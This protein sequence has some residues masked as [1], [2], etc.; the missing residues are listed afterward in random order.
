MR[1][2]TFANWVTEII[3]SCGVNREELEAAIRADLNAHDSRLRDMIVPEAM[4]LIEN[5]ERYDRVVLSDGEYSVSASRHPALVTETDREVRVHLSD[6][7]Y[8]IS[9]AAR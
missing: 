1:E 3:R 2:L 8:T 6:G 7:C 4:A 5:H 9:K